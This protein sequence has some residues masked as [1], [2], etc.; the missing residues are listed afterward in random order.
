MPAPTI[1][2][3]FAETRGDNVKANFQNQLNILKDRKKNADRYFSSTTDTNQETLN[4]QISALK[5]SFDEYVKSGGVANAINQGRDNNPPGGPSSTISDRIQTI[6]DKYNNYKTNVYEPLK[7]LRQ[8]VL[9]TVDVN[10]F[11]A[12]VTD[13]IDRINT[14]KEQMKQE[15]DN[16]AT[17][18]TREKMVETKD[19]AISYHQTWGFLERP[20][21]KRSI[22]IIIILTVALAVAAIVGVYLLATMGATTGDTNV[23]TNVSMGVTSMKDKITGIFGKNSS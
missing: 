20:L 6:K 17:S 13:Q 22:P 21:K 8:Q 19:T 15:E 10:S 1:E 18:Y 11:A 4:G 7:T 9:Q 23:A 3:G 14:L 12:N 5:A 16:L 2:E